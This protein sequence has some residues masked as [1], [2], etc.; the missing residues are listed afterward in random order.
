MRGY[1]VRIWS[2]WQDLSQLKGIYPKTWETILNNCRVQQFFGATSGLACESVASVSGYGDRH[3]VAELERDEMILNI[4]GDEPVVVGAAGEPRVRS[5]L[6]QIRFPDDAQPDPNRPEP[7][8]PVSGPPTSEIP[9]IDAQISAVSASKGRSPQSRR[10]LRIVVAVV[11]VLAVIAGAVTALG[12][13][14]W[15]NQWYVGADA[16]RVTIYQGLP[17]SVGGVPM[18]RTTEITETQ[19]AQLPVFDAELIERGIAADSLDDARRIAE[20]MA[21]RAAECQRPRPPAGCPTLE[22]EP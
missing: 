8:P 13:V 12:A 17:G 4:A 3:A 11:A 2:F 1:G 9:R 5:R 20:E 7:P 18:H 6:P 16:G 15:S 10:A 19:V 22:I 14:W 21:A